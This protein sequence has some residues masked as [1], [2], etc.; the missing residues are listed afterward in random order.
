MND[1]AIM[2][3]SLGDKFLKL[4]KLSISKLIETGNTSCV[5]S[6]Q[7]LEPD[8]IQKETEWSD[9]DIAIPVLFN[10]YHGLELMLKGAINLNEDSA[11]SH[12]FSD[13]ISQ[14]ESIYGKNRLIELIKLSTVEIPEKFESIDNPMISFLNQNSIDIDMWFQA[15]KYPINKNKVFKHF[16]L[17]YGG[18]RTIPFWKYIKNMSEEISEEA[19][20]FYHSFKVND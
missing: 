2:Y 18:C 11:F 4:S 5:L 6:E 3:F 15:L 7:P 13:L 8:E 1:K 20:I 10:F 12:K 17:K 16:S 19:A 9:V 14:Y